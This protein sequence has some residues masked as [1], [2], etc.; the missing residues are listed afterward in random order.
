MDQPC[1]APML[2]QQAREEIG[3]RRAYDRSQGIQ[4]LQE[5]L[6]EAG[7]LA[8]MVQTYHIEQPTK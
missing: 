5:E 6:E 2:M 7:T 8:N 4:K 1:D 3:M